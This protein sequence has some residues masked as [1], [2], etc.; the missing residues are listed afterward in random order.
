VARTRVTWDDAV[1]ARIGGPLTLLGL[2]AALYLAMPLLGLAAPAEDFARQ[3]LRSGLFVVF[4]WALMRSV[5]VLVH[6][7]Q[8]S[9][10]TSA[11]PAAVSLIPLAG[12]VLKILVLA[13][14]IVSALSALGFPV[15]SLIA[16]LGI[17]GLAVA[18]AAQKTVE[19][20]VG[21]FSIGVDQPFKEGDMVK[22]GEHQGNVETIGLRSTRLRTLDR[23][24]V[25]IPNAQ[26]SEQRVET[27]AARDRIRL[28]MTIGLEYGAT[29][30]QILAV[31]EGFERVLRGHPRIWTETVVV[32]FAGFGE[33]SLDLEILC[34]F[35]TMDI[36]EFRDCR[37]AVLLDFMEVVEKAGC[38][39]AF[40]TRTVHVVAEKAKGK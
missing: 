11:H 14:A 15:A 29:R 21:A 18:L 3:V 22:I 19:N 7:L 1:L 4:F 36:D 13:M 25:T 9:S 16:G 2:V 8:E 35:D 33:S 6:M 40:P 38:G 20:L 24:L 34:W 39:F 23:T 10:W 5:D 17:G 31:V 12:S 27:F 37:Q 26:V 32:R 30:A 28:A